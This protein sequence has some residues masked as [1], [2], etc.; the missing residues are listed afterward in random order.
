MSRGIP[1]H[2][3]SNASEPSRTDELR[4]QHTTAERYLIRGGAIE[5]SVVI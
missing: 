5:E 4:T 1:V 2:T 3:H